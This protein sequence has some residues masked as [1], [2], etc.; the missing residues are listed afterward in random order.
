MGGTSCS[1]GSGRCGTGGGS[2]GMVNGGE[3]HYLT[4]VKS[5]QFGV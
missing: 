3:E 1:S 4:P 5:L 2:G